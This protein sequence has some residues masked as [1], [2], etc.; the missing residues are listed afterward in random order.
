M[1]LPEELK[2]TVEMMS[3]PAVTKETKNEQ[4]VGRALF[5]SLHESS[6]PKASVRWLFNKEWEDTLVPVRLPKGMSVLL[7]LADEVREKEIA[8]DS[9][10]DCEGKD[11]CLMIERNPSEILMTFLMKL[12]FTEMIVEK[13]PK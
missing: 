3:D 1:T 5:E 10:K 9:C 8:E 11:E 6:D 13:G 4:K 7:K 2:E 12:A